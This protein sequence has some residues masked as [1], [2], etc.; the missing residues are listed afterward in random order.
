MGDLGRGGVAGEQQAEWCLIQ[1]NLGVRRG[2]R[3]EVLRD[4]KLWTLVF[5]RPLATLVSMLLLRRQWV[6]AQAL[7]SHRCGFRFSLGHSRSCVILDQS[8]SL[9]EPQLSAL[10]NRSKY[11]PHRAVQ[12]NQ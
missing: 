12:R 3:E 11:L 1:E 9:S 2:M 8:L 4:L 5:K 7:M 10:K 6:R